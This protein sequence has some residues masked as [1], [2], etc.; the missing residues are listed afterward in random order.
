LAAAQYDSMKKELDELA[1]QNQTL[2]KDFAESTKLLRQTQDKLFELEQQETA[3][4]SQERLANEQLDRQKSE[5]ES[6]RMQSRE[7]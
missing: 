7:S 2:R 5:L 4:T 1:F 6:T 3:R